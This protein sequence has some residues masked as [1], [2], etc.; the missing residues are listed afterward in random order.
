[1]EVTGHTPGQDTPRTRSASIWDVARVAGV[2]QQT[3]SRVIN[4]KARVSEET[5]AKVLQVIEEMGYRPNKLARVLAGGPVRSVTVLTSDTA[6]Y[7]AAATLRGMEEAART[8]G[9]SVG[10]SVLEPGSAQGDVA[11][12]LNRPGE[13]VMVIAF[14]DAGVRALRALPPDVPVAAAVERRPDAE[15]HD[16]WQV[17]LD[18][19]AA[20]AHATRYLL[21][22]GHRTVHY[23]AIPSSTTDLPQRTQGWMDA[24]R[25]V[26]GPV[27][28]PVRGGWSPRSGYL[29]VRDLVADP[30]VTAILCGNDD[31]ALGV[32]R[33]AREAGR[34]IPGDLSVVGFDDSPPAAFLNPALTTVRLD[35]EGLGRAC[36]GVLH[37]RLD[38]EAAPAVPAWS[39]PELIV[40][41]SSGPAPR[42]PA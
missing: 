28:E 27:P 35:F 7:G 18:D 8:A 20:A 40:R 4:G 32:M 36:F 16:S 11:E 37:R 38:P 3:V 31:L 42:S 22:L 41:E 15:A 19:R 33:A 23:L 39:E 34:T 29:A 1:M 25:A 26:G 21:G 24:L 30:S 6:L 17:W 10:I 13:A 14:D 9:F 5:R 12:R 2:S